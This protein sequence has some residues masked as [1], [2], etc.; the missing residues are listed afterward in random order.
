VVMDALPLIIIVLLLL[1]VPVLAVVR[2]RRDGCIL[3]VIGVEDRTA[4]GTILLSRGGD[5]C[6]GAT[7]DGCC[8][9]SFKDSKFAA[10]SWLALRLRWLF[11]LEESSLVFVLRDAVVIIYKGVSD[12]VTAIITLS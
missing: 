5:N 9:A 10:T 4:V 12:A 2:F 11:R 1:L 6:S 8:C 3:D 7:M